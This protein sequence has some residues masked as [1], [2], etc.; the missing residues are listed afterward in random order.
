[1]SDLDGWTFEVRGGGLQ[2]AT[3]GGEE[4]L[5]TDG[6]LWSESESH[7]TPYPIAVVLELIRRYDEARNTTGK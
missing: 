2:R 7:S 5:L 3:K 6:N 4:L 1:M